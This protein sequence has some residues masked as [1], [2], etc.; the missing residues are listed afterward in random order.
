[1][2][3]KGERPNPYCNCH[4]QIHSKVLLRR[5]DHP[6]CPS[7]RASLIPGIFVRETRLGKWVQHYLH[8]LAIYLS[9]LQII[10]I[11]MY[12]ASALDDLLACFP[13]IIK[14][15]ISSYDRSQQHADLDWHQRKEESMYKTGKM[16]KV[17]GPEVTWMSL[18][19]Q[20]QLNQMVIETAVLFSD[21]SGSLATSMAYEWWLSLFAWVIQQLAFSTSKYRCTLVELFWSTS[22]QTESSPCVKRL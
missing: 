16:L 11:A 6:S 1:M 7:G 20:F 4:Q 9:R 3:Q 8:Q 13:K 15:G 17:R 21:C 18:V 10:A 12:Q 19:D 2:R 22:I 14:H 5:S